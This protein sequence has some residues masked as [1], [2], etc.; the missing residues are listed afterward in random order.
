M[1]NKKFLIKMM[2]NYGDFI[3]DFQNKV[4]NG[5]WVNR[6]P[7]CATTDFS[8]KYIRNIRRTERF[9]FKGNIL[10]FNWTDN[11]FEAIPLKT[12]KGISPLSSI[13]KNKGNDNG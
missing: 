4:V 13:L 5:E 12:I 3:I 1:I 10:V 8:T 6:E 7:I 2:S 9:P 11:K